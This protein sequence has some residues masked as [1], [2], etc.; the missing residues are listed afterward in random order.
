MKRAF[1]DLVGTLSPFAVALLLTGTPAIASPAPNPPASSTPA[2]PAAPV[3]EL[4][5][6]NTATLEQLE[7]LPGVGTVYAAKIVAGRP[8]RTK[9]DLVNR[10]I[11]PAAN[12]AKFR[13]LVI[14]KQ[15]AK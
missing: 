12:Y 13:A 15:P 7:A 9:Q 10:K 8:Y 3:V 4:L 5:D 6:L 2:H 14:A 11:V 1:R